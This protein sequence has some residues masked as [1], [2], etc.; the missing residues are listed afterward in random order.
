MVNTRM[1]SKFESLEHMIQ[2]DRRDR[3]KAENEQMER[4]Q[5]MENLISGLLSGGKDHLQPHIWVF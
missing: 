1:E 3:L 5:R 2:E 4:F